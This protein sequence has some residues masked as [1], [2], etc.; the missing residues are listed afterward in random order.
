MFSV[1]VCFQAE[2]GNIEYK[3][4]KFLCYIVLIRSNFGFKMAFLTAQAAEQL[5]V[6]QFIT[7]LLNGSCHCPNH[8]IV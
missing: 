5:S 4:T 1:F 3:V 2:E 6:L 8:L 7:I